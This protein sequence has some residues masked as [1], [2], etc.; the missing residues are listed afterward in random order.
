ML[1]AQNRIIRT[2]HTRVIG[3]RVLLS[4]TVRNRKSIA[5]NQHFQNFKKIDTTTHC[6]DR[7][8]Q[9][10]PL[11]RGI[12]RNHCEKM[13]SVIKTTVYHSVLLKLDGFHANLGLFLLFFFFNF[14]GRYFES[15]CDSL[16]TIAHLESFLSE[17]S[18][19]MNHNITQNISLQ[20]KQ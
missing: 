18:F 11:S 5:K 17:P 15:C 1:C 7:H 2:M 9:D 10:I 3:Y 8:I 12:C 16:E 14:V 13:T 20:K 19:L 6:T 4:I